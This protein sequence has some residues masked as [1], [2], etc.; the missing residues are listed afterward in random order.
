ML[1]RL[2]FCGDNPPPVA[3]RQPRWGTGERTPQT[4]CVA[5]LRVS[6][7][8]SL[9]LPKRSAFLNQILRPDDLHFAVKADLDDLGGETGGT[10]FKT[11]IDCVVNRAFDLFGDV[12]EFLWCWFP[13]DV[14]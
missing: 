10:G 2:I 1:F 7:S 9:S 13:G 4:P 3:L 12:G 14:R 5:A 11:R 6:Q 8:R